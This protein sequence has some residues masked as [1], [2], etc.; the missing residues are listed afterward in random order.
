[1]KNRNVGWLVVGISIFVFAIIG[2]FN[3]GVKN[4]LSATCSH[5]TSC[6]MYQTL[7]MQ[8]WISLAIAAII[9]LIGLFLVFSKENERIVIKKIRPSAK[10]EPKEFDKRSI[11]KLGLDKQEKEIM[12]LILQNKGSIFQSQIVE[13]SGLNKVRITRVLDSLEGQGLIERKR[14]GMTNVIVL[15]R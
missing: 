10:L 6:T 11:E 9:L 13:K 8:T 1:M 2:I 3:Y 4:V 12:N 5:G 15:K 14:R 7:S